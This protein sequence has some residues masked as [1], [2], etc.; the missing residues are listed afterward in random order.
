MKKIILAFIFVSICLG[1]D[2]KE[3]T[4][5]ES[6]PEFQPA[7]LKLHKT[8]ELKKRGKQLWKILE[9]CRLCPRICGAN[10]LEGE[11]GFCRAPDEL[12]ISTY[13]PHFGEEKPLVGRGGSG[14]IFFSHCNL[15]CVFCI[16]WETSHKGIG[17]SKSIKD[18]AEI[19][20]HLQKIGCHNINLVTPSHYVAHIVLAVDLAAKKGLRL[21]LVYNTCG[22]ERMEILKLLDGIVDI[23]LPDFKYSAPEMAAKYS[24]GAYTYPEITKQALLEM[25]RQVGVATPAKDGLMYRG[26]M[27]RHLVMPNNVGGTKEVLKWIAENL[28]KDTYVNIMSQYTPIYKAFEY[29]EISRR[30]TP[31][32]Y[33][34]VVDYAK[35]L[36]LTNLDIQGMHF[37]R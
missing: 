11:I 4:V 26:L 7:Y 10:R 24:A 19:M 18:L 34:E 21:P 5:K 27:I 14:A 33:K 32:E 2:S 6:I 9:G 22:W 35:K 1:C 23:Y 25:H 3:K 29:P 16:N 12:I 17:N 8:G 31:K 30:I 13:H 37:L 15:R 28:P 20:L 36:G